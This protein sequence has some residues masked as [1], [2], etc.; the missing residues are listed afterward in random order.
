MCRVLRPELQLLVHGNESGTLLT[1]QSE[2]DTGSATFCVTAQDT[3]QSH[4][5]PEN[6]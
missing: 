3:S 5:A 2:L 4:T 1:H 6:R